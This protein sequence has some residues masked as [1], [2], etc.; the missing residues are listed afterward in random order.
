[1]EA[2]GRIPEKA[3]EA[4]IDAVSSATTLESYT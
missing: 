4:G 2:V 1:M 3:R